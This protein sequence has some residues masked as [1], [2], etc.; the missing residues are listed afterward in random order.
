MY[1]LYNNT[2][3]IYMTQ[4]QKNISLNHLKQMKKKY[5]VTTSGTKKDIAQGLWR[6]RQH[7]MADKD[8]TNIIH[9]LPNPEQADVQKLIQSR[10]TP[11]TN[12]KGMWK[13][14]PT[15]KMSRKKLITE[16]KSF[17]TAWEKHTR[18]DQDLSNERLTTAPVTE[19]RKLLKF[20]YS[21]DAKLLARDW[22]QK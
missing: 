17:K 9:L 14:I 22:L 1:S 21:D 4:S 8:L 20:Y 2:I 13:P 15:G 3:L 10:T 6:V 12:Y 18:R 7:A 5:K 19:L 16:L 11:I